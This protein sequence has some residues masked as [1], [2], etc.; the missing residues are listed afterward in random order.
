MVM[1]LNAWLPAF[2]TIW[3]VA[4]LGR[5]GTD[6]L[7]QEICSSTGLARPSGRLTPQDDNHQAV[8]QHC[9]YCHLQAQALGLPPEP[10][11]FSTPLLT[12]AAPLLF[13]HGPRTLRTWAATR[14]RAPPSF[15]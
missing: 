7:T 3:Q 6:Q 8:N 5:S 1:L 9:P 14:A 10:V 4:D 15:S 11:E 13:W 2:A 12:Q